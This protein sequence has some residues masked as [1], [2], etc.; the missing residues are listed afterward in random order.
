MLDEGSAGEDAQTEGG[1]SSHSCSLTPSTA[2]AEAA[3]IEGVQL[4]EQLLM[5]A[6]K[7]AAEGQGQVRINSQGAQRGVGGVGKSL[8]FG[9]RCW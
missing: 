5:V 8:L 7:A 3:M 2:A 9:D 4:S 1:P 6:A